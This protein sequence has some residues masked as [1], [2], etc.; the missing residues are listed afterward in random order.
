MKKYNILITGVGA[1]IG[2]G[3]ISSLRKSKYEVNII[4]IDIYDDAVGQ[5]WCDK[6]YQAIRASDERY[7]QYLRDII[8]KESIDL[9]F[10]GTEQEILKVVNSKQ[11]LLEVYHKF[12]LNTPEVLKIS[13]DKWRTY[14]FLLEHNI[15]AIPTAIEG[16]YM[17][18][19]KEYG[20]V[21]LIKPR[22]SY[23]SKGLVIVDNETDYNYWKDKMKN[24]F[25]VQKIIGNEENEY[26][27]ANFGYGDGNATEPICFRR[28]L[29]SG[30]ATV[31]AEVVHIEGLKDV[32]Q[33]ITKNLKPLGPTNYQFREEKGK[34]L[35]L[36]INPRLSSSTSLRTLFGFNE[37]EMCIK[38]FIEKK[39]IEKIEYECGSAVRYIADLRKI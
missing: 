23:A 18:L 10:F 32:V 27:V 4:G 26:T 7:I 25:M 1:I 19:K 12:V 34:Y 11:E 28:K 29:G 16:N 6:F 39:T 15:Q 17:E 24:Q 20:E 5:V 30:G 37:A 9:A 35:L 14:Q 13:Q 8:N 21:L 31:K 38:Y 3:I 2:Y 33:S 22:Q 36:E